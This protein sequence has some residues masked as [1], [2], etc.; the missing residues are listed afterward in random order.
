[1]KKFMTIALGLAVALSTATLTF[2][3][4]DKKGEEK[5]EGKKKKGKKKKKEEEKK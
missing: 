5:K 4:E 2:G 3:Q 1:M